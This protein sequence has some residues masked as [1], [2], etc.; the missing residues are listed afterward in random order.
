MET[1]ASIRI[2]KACKADSWQSQDLLTRSKDDRIYHLTAAGEQFFA[3]WQIDVL[4]LRGTRRHFAK[5]FLD[6]TERRPHV[7]GALGAAI[8]RKFLEFHWIA[9]DQNSRF[10]RV[11][12]LGSQHLRSLLE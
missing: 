5:R 3:R 4:T 2:P 9:R 8:Y 10:V 1:S 12:A 6:W 11:T 7:A